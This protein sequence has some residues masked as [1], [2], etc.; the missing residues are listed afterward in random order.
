MLWGVFGVIW[1]LLHKGKPEGLWSFSEE[2]TITMFVVRSLFCLSPC[3]RMLLLYDSFRLVHLSPPQAFGFVSGAETWLTDSCSSSTDHYSTVSL[4]KNYLRWS[5]FS[6]SPWTNLD[7]LVFW[8]LWVTLST[9]S[10]SL[11]RTEPVSTK[12]HSHIYTRW[13]VAADW[14]TSDESIKLTWASSR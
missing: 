12:R 7:V 5:C 14:F 4:S 8:W 2:R 1:S 10:W 13:T 11:D 9:S 3:A 6:V